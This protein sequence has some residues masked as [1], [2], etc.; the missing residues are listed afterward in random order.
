M[1]NLKIDAE[2]LWDD[3]METAAIGGTPKGGI[4]RLTLTDLDRQ[5][6]DWFKAR[7]EALGCTRHGRRHGRDVRAPAGH[8]PTCRRSPWAAISTPSRPAASSTACSACWPRSRRCARCV[9][10]GYETFAPIEVVNWTNEEGSRFA[11]AMIA[12]GVFA[13]VF[14]ARLGGVRGRTARA[15]TF[16]DALDAIGYR[17]PERCGDA[18]AVGLLRAAHRAGADPR[19]RGQGHRRRHRRAGRCAGTRSTLTGQDAHTGTTP[20]HAAQERAARR[21]A[22]DRARSRRSRARMAR[23][24]SAPSACSR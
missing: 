18:S 21:R 11:P 1:T 12:S 5:V 3:L 6:R 8:A 22:H 4:C 16:G 24:R 23:W 19:S 17:G 14:D 2:R 13:G 20:M 15:S 9:E 7:A 10:A